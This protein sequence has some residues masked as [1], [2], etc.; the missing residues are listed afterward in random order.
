MD[1]GLLSN[2]PYRHE[3]ALLE[4]N[5]LACDMFALVKRGERNGFVGPDEREK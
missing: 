3:L 5:S 1:G 4:V 2:R